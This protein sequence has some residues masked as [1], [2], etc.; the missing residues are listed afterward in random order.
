MGKG[1]YKVFFKSNLKALCILLSEILRYEY[2]NFEKMGNFQHILKN[3]YFRL[4]PPTLSA[5]PSPNSQV[6]S[7]SGPEPQAR[8]F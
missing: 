2:R 4:S 7:K 3:V 1:W 6:F 8:F 5:M